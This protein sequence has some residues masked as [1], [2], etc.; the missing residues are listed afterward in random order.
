M[1]HLSHQY[2]TTGKTIAF[3]R[4][5]FISKVM[6]LLLSILSRSVIA[7]LPRSKHILISRLQL[8]S[9]VILESKKIKPI[10]ISIVSVST[11]FPICHEEMGSG[12]MT[13]VFVESYASFFTLLFHL[14]QR[15]FNSS[16]LSAMGRCHLHIW[17]YWYLFQQ[18]WFQLLLH[19]AR[20]FT[21]C[22]LHIS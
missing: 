5:P 7:F 14:P 2:M 22:T 15:L 4:Q 19:S 20:H 1:I 17:N 6:S 16:L 8:P 3:T 21:W 12:V 13:L 11:V 18:S 9:A 10:T